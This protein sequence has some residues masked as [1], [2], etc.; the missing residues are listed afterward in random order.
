MYKLTQK[1]YLTILSYY[2]ITPPKTKRGT[3]HYKKLKITAEDILAKKLCKC[4]KSVDPALLNEK[5]AI[6]ICNNQLFKQR[7]LKHFHFKCKKGTK[8]F[9]QNG[10]RKALVKTKKNLKMHRRTK[11]RRK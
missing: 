5:K 2:G 8:L 6:A 7:G 3:I 9:P 4:I 1:D 10:T 11:K